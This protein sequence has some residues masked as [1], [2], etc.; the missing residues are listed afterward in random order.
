MPFR[1]ELWNSELFATAME[2]AGLRRGE[3]E[4]QTEFSSLRPV[5][6]QSEGT[7]RQMWAY[8]LQDGKINLYVVPDE[9]FPCNGTVIQQAGAGLRVGASTR[10]HKMHRNRA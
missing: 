7:W 2:L 5:A 1:E 6:Q 3:G 10:N 9:G 8:F 4:G